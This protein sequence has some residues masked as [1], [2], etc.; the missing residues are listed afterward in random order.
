MERFSTLSHLTP[1]QAGACVGSPQTTFLQQGLGTLFDLPDILIK[2]SLGAS[3]CQC[4]FDSVCL[5]VSIPFIL[6][7]DPSYLNKNHSFFF[8][9][10]VIRPFKPLFIFIFKLKK[11]TPHLPNI[12]LHP[13]SK[14]SSTSTF[15]IFFYFLIK[16]HLQFLASSSCF[17]L[18]SAFDD[19]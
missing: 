2:H 12:F 9:S 14:Y 6:L 16:V 19:F 1:L 11:C 13:P 4:V 7:Q 8:S 18:S 15:Q 17:D 3:P 10:A 5:P